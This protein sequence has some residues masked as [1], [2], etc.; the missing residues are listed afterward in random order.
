MLGSDPCASASWALPARPMQAAFRPQGYARVP[1][2]K[3]KP[4][5]DQR[6]SNQSPAHRRSR[7]A[8]RAG[9]SL[10]PGT[11]QLLIADA[12]RQLPFEYR[13]VIYRAYYRGW[14]TERIADDL[15]ITEAAVKSR[16]HDGLRTLRL[17]S[18]EW[19]GGVEAQPN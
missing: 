4:W 15:K 1:G 9:S 18:T 10:T 7:A 17:N 11:D 12:M 8:R 16:L 13:A 14:T 19:G 5:S 6:G 2:D 3:G